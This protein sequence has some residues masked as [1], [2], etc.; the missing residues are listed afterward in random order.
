MAYRVL[1]APA[2]ALVIIAAALGDLGG[3]FEGGLQH[4][5][6]QYYT[7]SVTD[8]VYEL[9]RR[10]QEGQVHLKFE[11]QQGYVGSLL[12]ALGIP[13][14]SQL[15]VFSKTSLLARMI[16]PKHPRSIFFNDSVSV[17]WIPGEPF[18][19]I[20]A[21]DATQGTVFYALDNQAVEKPA[22]T[23]HNNDC[24]N[25]HNTFAS[26]GVPGM[27]VRSV[28][29]GPDGTPLSYLGGTFPDGRTPI[30][31]RWGG[32]YVTGKHVPA[33]HRG[34][35]RITIQNQSQSSVLTASA[36][37]E[38]LQGM[39]DSQAY[40]TPY[41]DVVA[42]LVFEHQMHMMNLFTRVGWDVRVAQHV[43]PDQVEELVDYLLFVDEWPLSG[44]VQGNSGFT[45]KFEA[46]GPRDSQGRSLRQF[47]LEHRLMRYPCSYM[48]YSAAFDG[49]PAD[50]KAAIYKRMWLI[51]SGQEHDA[52]Y[53]KL[54]P[55][56]RGAVV[57]ILRDTKPESRTYFA[58]K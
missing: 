22:L 15:L 32:W 49:L 41:S 25:C 44:R 34:N 19:E 40:L 17:T 3:M 48:I 21:Q 2:A 38:S 50:A 51:L 33:G 36:N 42:L 31:E 11:G 54:T 20:A 26:L 8:P 52:R 4:P 29:T 30:Q 47:D 28:L 53:A 57:E 43:L 9:N 6:V 10:L 5:A 24:L 27:T 16:N 1:I 45:E 37:L 7:R 58:T 39:F 56:D 12:E 14:E 55:A 23:R 35:S 18:V 13:K 46:E